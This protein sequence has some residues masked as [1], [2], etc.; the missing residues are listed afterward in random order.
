MRV[1]TAGKSWIHASL[2]VCTALCVCVCVCVC[3][4]AC[5][6]EDFVYNKHKLGVQSFQRPSKV[7]EN[8]VE[9]HHGSS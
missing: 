9:L 1:K 8:I 7:K 2:C 4:F 6:W 5:I 3:V